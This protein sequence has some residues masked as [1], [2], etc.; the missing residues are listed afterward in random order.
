MSENMHKLD[1]PRD[2]VDPARRGSVD[3]G[4]GVVVAGEA[5]A[6]EPGLKERGVSTKRS[7]MS[8]SDRP[9]ERRRYQRMDI[10][11]PVECHQDR[12]T[13]THVVRTVTRNIGTGGIYVELE[14]PDF[15]EG[16]VIDIHLTLPAAEGVSSH[17]VRAR[18]RAEVL[19]VQRVGR[20]ASTR[21]GIAARFLDQLRISA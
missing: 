8:Q 20:D 5:P 11:L 17:P 18:T 10:R 16:D 12:V 14:A 13:G 15:S 2:I 9:D 1:N 6:F 21:Y 19:R 7:A 3:T 4:A